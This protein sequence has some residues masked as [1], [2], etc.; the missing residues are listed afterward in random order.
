MSTKTKLFGAAALA[1]AVL[2]VAALPASADQYN[3]DSTPGFTVNGGTG[4]RFDT[5]VPIAEGAT[6][7]DTNF[8]QVGDFSDV[9]LNGNPQLTSAQIAPFTII[10]DSG[11]G[12]G[13]NVTFT[14][15]NFQGTDATHPAVLDAT[16]A[17]MNAPVLRAGTSDSALGGVYTKVGI[18]FTGAGKKIVIADP[19]NLAAG[20]TDNVDHGN[21]YAPLSIDGFNNVAGMGTYL[22]SPQILKLI[23]PNTTIADDYVTTANFTIATGP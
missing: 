12:A 2:L 13:W 21:G 14:L 18:D 22:I 10:D 8:P 20:G 5:D 4:P 1:I 3:N 23:V 15:P 19:G 6:A 16:G 9:T 11:T 17:S 7:Q